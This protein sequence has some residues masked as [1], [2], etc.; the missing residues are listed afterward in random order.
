MA[1]GLVTYMTLQVTDFCDRQQVYIMNSVNFS[2]IFKIE[3]IETMLSNSELVQ[4]VASYFVVLV[5][6]PANLELLPFGLMPCHKT[7]R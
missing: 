1:S 2:K 6:Y 3:G 7:R 4:L 5:A